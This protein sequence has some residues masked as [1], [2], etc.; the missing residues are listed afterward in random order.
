M[1]TPR[2]N[3]YLDPTAEP[4]SGIVGRAAVNG[5]IFEYPK[6]VRT[7]KDPL[8]SD[9]RFTGVS[10]QIFE[11][12]LISKKGDQEVKV[13]GMFKVRGAYPTKDEALRHGAK[14]VRETDS[15][16]HIGIAEVGGW[17]PIVENVGE[18]SLEVLNAGAN[19]EQL[20]KERERMANKKE[21][22]EKYQRDKEAREYEAKKRE[23]ASKEIAPNLDPNHIDFFVTQ[24]TVWLK[25]HREMTEMAARLKDV[26]NK[27]KER[28]EILEWFR[29]Q[30][31]EFFE[32]DT[33]LARINEER[34]AVGA[35]REV[36]SPKE[37]EH[38]NKRLEATRLPKNV[39]RQAKDV[40]INLKGKLESNNIVKIYPE[41]EED[42]ALEEGDSEETKIAKA[43]NLKLYR[44]KVQLA[45]AGDRRAMAAVC[46]WKLDK[47]GRILGEGLAVEPTKP[48]PGTEDLKKVLPSTEGVPDIVPQIY[49][50]SKMSRQE[51]FDET[52]PDQAEMEHQAEIKKKLEAQAQEWAARARVE[53]GL[54]DEVPLPIL[55]AGLAK[56]KVQNID[57]WSNYS[58]EMAVAD[59]QTQAT[60]V[61]DDLKKIMAGV[62]AFALLPAGLATPLRKVRVWYTNGHTDLIMIPEAPFMIL[63]SEWE[64]NE[65]SFRADVHTVLPDGTRLY[66]MF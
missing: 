60:E 5:Q 40:I 55:D 35:V 62:M 53:D 23:Y 52:I 48:E 49:D 4:L 19:S 12:P 54:L 66:R 27:L 57:E 36:L 37:R 59:S 18:A 65:D 44:E 26:K 16:F 21:R 25:L 22:M 61:R 9:Q 2:T 42:Y 41:Y 34:K 33:W 15:T 38:F 43:R 10:Y 1:T 46:P 29:R 13:L 17:N 56:T 31:P 39:E 24:V 58:S 51:L 28:H 63:P 8:I 32:G 11:H 45:A 47:L 20:E 6:V 14:I 7:M 64:V 3:P 30:R 50:E